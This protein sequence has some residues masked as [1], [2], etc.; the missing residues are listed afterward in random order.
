MF[1]QISNSM[2][3]GCI[4]KTLSKIKWNKKLNISRAKCFSTRH[5]H[6]L[7]HIQINSLTPRIYI[8]P[9]VE[10]AALFEASLDIY[11]V[12]WFMHSTKESTHG[13]T[14]ENL[15]VRVKLVKIFSI[16]IQW[17]AKENFFNQ[18]LGAL[19]F[20]PTVAFNFLLWK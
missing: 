8:F 19:H 17:W 3:Y 4:S 6:I 11:A 13:Y 2:E 1:S 9:I 20:L 18:I 15:Q 16:N 10:T 7:A 14:Y 5:M 12:S